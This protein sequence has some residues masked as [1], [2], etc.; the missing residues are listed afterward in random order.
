MVMLRY[1]RSAKIIT[2]SEDASMPKN[3]QITAVLPVGLT[4]HTMRFNK[5]KKFLRNRVRRSAIVETV[6]FLVAAMLLNMF[7]GDGTRFINVSPHPFWI[8][9]LLITLQY[10]AKE[11]LIASLLSSA[12]LLIG[13]LPEQSLSQS[14]YGYILH[15]LSLPFLWVVTSL[16]LG[17]IRTRQENE[18][19]SLQKQLRK[20]NSATEVITEG[21]N[22]LKKA[23]EQLEL[24]LAAEK[25]SVLTMYEVAKSLETTD[26]SEAPAAVAK[27]VNVTIKPAKFSIY[28]WKDDVLTLDAAYGWKHSDTFATHFDSNSPLARNM[29]KTNRSSLSILNENEENILKGQGIIAGTIYDKRTGKIFGML[30]IEEI[31]FMDLSVRTLETFLIVCEWIAYVYTNVDKYHNS[32][33]VMN[34]LPAT[35]QIVKNFNSNK[36]IRNQKAVYATN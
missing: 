35:E 28:R 20:A 7:V 14:L 13:N 27:L 19:R 32:T 18:K 6:L 29:L 5:T 24:R 12:V 31:A 15:V 8:I 9:V 21:Y 26:P 33:N 22:A 2:I 36:D 11:A 17:G 1:Y 10:G 23:K 4:K 16:V 25:C 30:K 3:N 34:I